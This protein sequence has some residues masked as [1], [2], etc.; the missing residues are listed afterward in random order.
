MGSRRARAFALPRA[1]R[2]AAVALS[3]ALGAWLAAAALVAAPPAHAADG[4]THESLKEPL[5][6]FPQARVLIDTGGRTHAFQV[7]IADTPPRRAQGLMWVREL[8]ADRGMLF[9]FERPEP[10]SFWMKNT[11]IPLDLLFV[12]PDGRIIRIAENAKP[13]SLAPIDSMG[14]ARG[15]LEL[16]GGTARRL[17]IRA[18]HRLR[19]PAFAPR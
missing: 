5:E 3:L 16:A 13:L 7:W 11:F 12:A 4:T 2:G 6:R 15:V 14:V 9:V 8:P 17:G 18:G 19:H 10:M 1:R